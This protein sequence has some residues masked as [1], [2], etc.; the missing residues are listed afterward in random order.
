MMRRGFTLVELLV[1]LVL[2]GLVA[3]A[4]VR[5]FV[6]THRLHDA[7]LDRLD[8]QANVRAGAAMLAAQ[9]REVARG[10]APAGDLVAIAPTSLAYRAV[11]GLYRTCRASTGSTVF[12]DAAPLHGHRLPD[13]AQDELTIYLP[14]EN[15]WARVD[16]VG[17]VVGTDCPG[18]APSAAVQVTGLAPAA[19]PGAPVRAARRFEL[20]LYQGG[21]GAWW[22][23]G[24]EFVRAT[25]AWAATQPIIGPAAAGGLLFTFLAADQSET[26][27]PG[28]VA[29]IGLTLV[30]LDRR[31]RPASLTVS[32]ALRN[33]A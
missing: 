27:D 12:L 8:L 17:L 29:R 31:G 5:L 28:Q 33:R 15:R 24:R 26:T 30:L 21:D 11:R 22:I 19:P 1:S 13:A 2:G 6:G 7:A 18:G 9:L 23:G 32:V 3:T 14:D 4:A 10:A 25:G 20:R 16:A